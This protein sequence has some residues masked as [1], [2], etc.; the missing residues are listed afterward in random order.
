MEKRSPEWPDKIYMQAHEV[1]K[2]SSRLM[3]SAVG[4]EF[5]TLIEHGVKPKS[6][7]EVRLDAIKVGAMALRFLAHLDMETKTEEKND[8]SENHSPRK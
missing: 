7:K 8:G 4:L 6:L 3:E 5:N 1:S 2:A